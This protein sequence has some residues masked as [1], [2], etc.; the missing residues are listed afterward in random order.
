[1]SKQKRFNLNERLAQY[2]TWETARLAGSAEATCTSSSDSGSGVPTSPARQI[3]S[4]SPAC[5]KTSTSPTTERIPDQ[6][7]SI[8][9]LLRLAEKFPT[10]TPSVEFV[11]DAFARSARKRPAKRTIEAA[12]LW[13]GKLGFWE[14][15]SRAAEW[16]EMGITTPKE[17][18]E[19]LACEVTGS[20]RGDAVSSVLRSVS[21]EAIM[22]SETDE[23]EDD[24]Y[25][26]WRRGD[27]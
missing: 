21:H 11:R 7:G 4:G 14:V 8:A 25:A 5:G 18:I 3:P 26:R 6:K 17:F 12:T 9:A 10:P 13:D 19:A 23:R 22:L 1:M 20:K 15:M 2:R 24:E 16:D 27:D